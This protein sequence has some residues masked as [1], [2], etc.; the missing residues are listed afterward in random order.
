MT[1]RLKLTPHSLP[2]QMIMSFVALV[3][4]TAAAAGLPAIW[5]IR[6]QLDRQAWAQVE[7]GSQAAQALYAAKQSE[8]NDLATLTAQRPTL[9]A[10]LAQRDDSALLTY[11]RT[12]QVGAKSDLM[13]VCDPARQTAAQT[14]Q[15]IPQNL[16]AA[17][18]PGGSYLVATDETPQLWLLTA[19][20]ILDENEKSLGAVIVGEALDDEFAAQMRTQTGLE[21]TLL[22]DGLPL[23]ASLTGGVTSRRSA[24]AVAHADA[25]R[26]TFDLDGRPYYAIRFPLSSTLQ[27]EVG[28]GANLEA[29]VALAVADLTATQRRLAWTLAGSIVTVA[30]LGSLLGMFLARQISR[31]L[32]LLAE[33]AAAL[34]KGD[35]ASPLTVNA[36]VREVALVAQALEGARAELRHTLEALRQEKVWTDHLLE[37]IVEGIVTLDRQGRIT[38]FS[39][40]AERI[41]GWRRDEVM[42]RSCNRVFQSV[43]VDESFTELIPAPGRRRKIPVQLRD[44]RQAILAVTGARLLPPESGDARVA[45]VFRDVSE[46]E[47]VHRLLGHF[48]ANVAHEFR[49]PLSALAASVELLLD[50][51]PDLSAAELQELLTSLHLGVLGLQTLVD[52]LLESASIEAGRFRVSPRPSNLGE[53]IAEAIRTMQPLLDK[54]GQRLMVELPAAIPVVQ[55]D[56]R[57]TAQ[58][59]VNLLSNASKYGPDDSEIAIGATMHEGWVRVTVADQGPGVPLESRSVLFRRFVQPQTGQEKAQYGVGLGLSVVKAIVEA[60]S[61]QVGISDQSGE[62]SVFWFTLPVAG[63]R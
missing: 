34:S 2:A 54:H 59:L 1:K 3:L 7:Q 20:P 19:Q 62:G 25:R 28:Q 37:A 5:L 18:S 46:E 6:Y 57:R 27:K 50:Q 56:P 8:L 42:G 24:R 29:E 33:A 39:H 38:F 16:C 13:I 58:V 17:A 12:L 53:I 36:R 51:A 11:L 32:A 61:G 48:L 60:H 23:A 30:L 41:T 21:H 10:L 45:L 14:R 31:P 43:Q 63:E 4:L 44:G 47:V 40:G 35:L 49:T 22:V 9:H 26:D 52:N 15:T 55:A